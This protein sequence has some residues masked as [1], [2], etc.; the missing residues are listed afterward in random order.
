MVEKPYNPESSIVTPEMVAGF[1][2]EVYNFLVRKLRYRGNPNPESLADDLTQETIK[3]AIT[4]VESI[5]EPEKLKSWLYAIATNE[6]FN[7]Y[8]NPSIRKVDFLEDLDLESLLTSN[9]YNPE[10][11]LV[12]DPNFKKILESRLSMNQIT[13]L[14]LRLQ[15]QKFEEIAKELNEPLSTIKSRIYTAIELLKGL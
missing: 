3:K 9:E 7:H 13:V 10:T 12:Q 15:G 5:R 2:N 14:M 8:R 11:S 4:A 1:R 6:L